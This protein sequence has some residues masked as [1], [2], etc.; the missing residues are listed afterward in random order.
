MS[1]Y[2]GLGLDEELEKKTEGAQPDVLTFEQPKPKRPP[3]ITWD[4]GKAQYKL[5]LTAVAIS[6]VEQRFKRN[7][8]SVVTDDGIPPVTTMLTIIQ[9]AM[10]QFHHNMTFLRVQNAFDDYVANG[11]DQMKLL[12]DT[13]MPLLG[14]SGFFTDSQMEILTEEMKEADSPM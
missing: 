10:L 9:A 4:T 8:L 11:G 13:I 6:K 5:K 1:E 14:V 3:F 7:L 2:I 12:S